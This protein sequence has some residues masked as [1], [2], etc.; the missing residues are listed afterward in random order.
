M[1]KTLIMFIIFICIF[2]LLPGVALADVPNAMSY[3]TDSSYNRSYTDDVGLKH[4]IAVTWVGETWNKVGTVIYSINYEETYHNGEEYYTL[5]DSAIEIYENEKPAYPDSNEFI[6][7]QV[8]WYPDRSMKVICDYRSVETTTLTEEPTEFPVDEPSKEAIGKY[9]PTP[10]GIKIEEAK[11]S[12]TPMILFESNLTESSPTAGDIETITISP[13]SETTYQYDTVPEE[14]VQS[15]GTIVWGLYI[16]FG[17]V[18]LLVIFIFLH[19]REVKRHE[20]N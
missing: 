14:D 9:E 6:V 5:V 16:V 3:F 15:R 18:I 1:K 7:Y 8:K 20:N 10:S 2:A 4:T 12:E 11:P 19:K 17:L 13:S